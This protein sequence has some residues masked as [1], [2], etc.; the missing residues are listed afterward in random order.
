M[1]LRK[2]LLAQTKPDISQTRIVS[3]ESEAEIQSG[4]GE[5]PAQDVHE[6]V[7]ENPPQSAPERKAPSEATGSS[8]PNSG[9]LFLVVGLAAVA[10]VALFLR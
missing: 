7:P 8:V 4:A 3:D 9:V 1:S 5:T 10:A 2:N 6:T